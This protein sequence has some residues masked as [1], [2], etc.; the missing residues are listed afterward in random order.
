HLLRLLNNIDY[1]QS[2]SVAVSGAAGSGKTVLM[3]WL[4]EQARAASIQTARVAA[5]ELDTP[6]GV[7]NRLLRKLYPELQSIPHTEEAYQDFLGKHRSEWRIRAGLLADI[8]ERGHA[9]VRTLEAYT[10]EQRTA[11]VSALIS[12]L[13]LE[14][15]RRSRLLIIIEDT[16]F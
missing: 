3:D 12:Q 8:L 14:Y 10:I 11:A 9:K 5:S 16:Q 2:A 4:S 1:N 13:L 7:W 6:Y 15:A